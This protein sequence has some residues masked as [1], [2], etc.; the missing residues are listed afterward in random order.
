MPVRQ[1]NESVYNVFCSIILARG[2]AEKTHSIRLSP[3]NLPPLL[4]VLGRS[5]LLV[6]T[7]AAGEGNLR[8]GG[9]LARTPRESGRVAV[10][11]VE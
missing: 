5:K 1:I 8:D 11:H 3:Q 7:N 4:A 9:R 2:E 10:G 6:A